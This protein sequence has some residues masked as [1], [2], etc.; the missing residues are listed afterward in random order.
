[1]ADEIL[2][3]E[4][5]NLAEINNYL[6]DLPSVAFKDVKQVFSQAVTDA[7]AKTKM[8]F[9]TGGLKSR[10]GML[11]R[12]LRTS[13]TGISLNSL[14]ASIYSASNVSG[15]P[16]RYAVLHEYGGTVR[17]IDKYRNVPGGPYL[18]IPTSANKTPVGVMKKSA[19]MLFNEGAYIKKSKAGNWGVFLGSQMMMLL[20]KEV[21]IPARLGMR[22][23]AD[24]QFPTILSKIADLFGK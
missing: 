17:A 16:V 23:A 24:E 10:T 4:V 3:V 22:D 12:S 15:T 8:S 13:V 9:V 18:N 20:R 11:W 1:M 2:R 7:D 5:K 14:R 21:T 6:S 19:R